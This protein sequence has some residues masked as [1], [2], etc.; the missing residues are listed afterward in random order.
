ML[1]SA[2]GALSSADPAAL[3]R[4]EL[5]SRQRELDD[6]R[7]ELAICGRS[8]VERFKQREAHLLGLI[9]RLRADVEELSA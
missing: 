5:H 6:V 8:E 9:L 3:Y 2:S 7:A 1:V 4:S